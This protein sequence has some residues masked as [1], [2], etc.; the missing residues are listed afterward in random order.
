V[1]IDFGTTVTRPIVVAALADG[2]LESVRR[3]VGINLD[4]L[5]VRFWPDFDTYAE[6]PGL[7][8]SLDTHLFGPGHPDRWI[9]L[10]VPPMVSVDVTAQ[11][12]EGDEPDSYVSATAAYRTA[13][14][15]VVAIA[16]ILT[17]NDL[18]DGVLDPN[19]DQIFETRL[20]RPDQFV[21][22][23]QASGLPA[24]SLETRCA[25]VLRGT[26]AF[27]TWAVLAR[28]GDTATSAE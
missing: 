23:F 18:G 25:A 12:H 8:E 3:I 6:L 24:G 19:M 21:S 10:T 26:P 9:E 17:A 14:S 28:S 22:R 2:V 20:E 16:S 5:E 11:S 13:S 27:R 15:V 7:D 1:S 4:A